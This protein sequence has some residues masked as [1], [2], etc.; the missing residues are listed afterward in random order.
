MGS[1]TKYVITLVVTGILGGGVGS[2]ESAL[3]PIFVHPKPPIHPGKD[4]QPWAGFGHLRFTSARELGFQEAKN[5]W[6]Q[7]PS[8]K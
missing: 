1:P 2:K 7:V 3:K 5:G 4:R 6:S 8:W